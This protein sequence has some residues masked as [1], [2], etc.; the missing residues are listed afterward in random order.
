MCVARWMRALSLPRPQLWPA[1]L[2]LQMILQSLDDFGIQWAVFRDCPNGVR[3]EL[4][5]VFV[6]GNL[7]QCLQRLSDHFASFIN[8]SAAWSHGCFGW[9]TSTLKYDCTGAVPALA[10]M[11]RRIAVVHPTLVETSEPGNAVSIHPCPPGSPR[12]PVTLVQLKGSAVLLLFTEEEFG[13]LVPLKVKLQPAAEQGLLSFRSGTAMARTYNAL[14]GQVRPGASLYHPVTARPLAKAKQ[15][16]LLSE[17]VGKGFSHQSAGISPM[18]L[19]TKRVDLESSGIVIGFRMVRRKVGLG[20]T[21]EEIGYTTALSVYVQHAEVES[22]G[23][24]SFCGTDAHSLLD[25]LPLPQRS[26]ATL[27][28]E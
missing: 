22:P 7:Y 27:R 4:A 8:N 26:L 12:G 20:R 15:V 9:T 21:R 10:V 18:L 11:L 2:H 24:V 13:Q 17:I 1:S 6:Y 25:S 23:H 16:S 3:K 5:D 28:R 14:L 19:G